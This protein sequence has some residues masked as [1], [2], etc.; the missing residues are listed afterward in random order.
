MTSRFFPPPHGEER[1]LSENTQNQATE[2]SLRQWATPDRGA[3]IAA[4]SGLL[5]A[6]GPG[7]GP[8]VIGSEL[9]NINPGE[10]IAIQSIREGMWAAREGDPNYDDDPLRNDVFDMTFN[11]GDLLG[12]VGGWGG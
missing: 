11:P 5:E 7:D 9:A 2:R 6:T 12:D 4:R 3:S 10:A 1:K 8:A